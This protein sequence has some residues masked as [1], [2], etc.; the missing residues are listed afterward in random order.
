[1]TITSEVPIPELAEVVPAERAAAAWT[2]ELSDH[3]A[4]GALDLR[5]AATTDDG[6]VWL[7]ILRDETRYVLRFPELAEFVITP[8][9]RQVSCAAA[10]EG[11]GMATLRHLF[12]DQVVPH[13]LALD[14]SLVLHASAVATERGAVAFLG[15][16]GF[17]KSSLAA[18]FAVEGFTLLADDFVLLAEGDS[19]FLATPS[20]PGLRLWPDSLSAF[21]DA[22]TSVSPVSDETEKQRVMLSSKP[23]Q[24]G[25][26]PLVAIVVLGDEP[27]EDGPAFVLRALSAREGL[28]AVFEHAF[29][30]ERLGRE[31]QAAEFDRFARLMQSTEVVH[32]EYRRDYEV[33][34]AV[35][36]EI[37]RALNISG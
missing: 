12:L 34:P 18:G 28:M 27:T 5:H 6:R 7:E 31:R 35:R 13:V 9:Q 19:G 11:V 14:G 29:R 10:D 17:G 23:D 33:L 8:S 1:M 37:L 3:H 30:I 20:Y 21:G 24:F 25:A 4:D 36:A 26:T 22:R 32:L 15:P 2:F 16:S